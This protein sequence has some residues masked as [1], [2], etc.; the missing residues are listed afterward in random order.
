MQRQFIIDTFNYYIKTPIVLSEYD[1]II[2]FPTTS[3]K[4]KEC[5][6]ISYN[7]VERYVKEND[8]FYQHKIMMPPEAKGRV[9]T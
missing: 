1:M 4:S 2:F 9:T 6:W 7:N 3:P 8:L 5:I